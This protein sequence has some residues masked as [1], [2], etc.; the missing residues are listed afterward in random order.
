MPAELI[1]DAALD[2]ASVHC[3]VVGDRALPVSLSIGTTPHSK[4]LKKEKIKNAI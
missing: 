3:E 1:E 4:R 2:G